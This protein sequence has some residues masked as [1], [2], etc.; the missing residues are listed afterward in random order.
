M[1]TGFTGRWGAA[2]GVLSWKSGLNF[3]RNPNLSFGTPLPCVVAPVAACVAQPITDHGRYTGFSVDRLIALLT[4]L[5]IDVD[6][7]LCPHSEHGS[8]RGMVRVV[9]VTLRL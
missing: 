8:H 2:K 5:D 4:A 3:P 6:I 9:E 1:L 7:V